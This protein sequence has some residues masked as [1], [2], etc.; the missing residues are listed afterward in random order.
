MNAITKDGWVPNCKLVFNASR[1]TGDYHTNM[2]WDNFSKWFKESLL[3]NIPPDSLII[4]D[5]APYHN[6]LLNETF[7]KKAHSIHNPLE[8]TDFILPIDLKQ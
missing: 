1:K 6:V 8:N 7:P 5:N 4:M 3:K 2:N